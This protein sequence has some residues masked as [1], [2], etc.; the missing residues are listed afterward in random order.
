MTGNQLREA[1]RR[2]GWTQQQAARRLGVSQGYFSLLERNRRRLPDQLTTKLLRVL[3][4]SPTARP[5][6]RPEQWKPARQD[7]L[8]GALGALGYPAF[9]YLHSRR[10][11][12]PAELLL[13]S[14]T[15]PNLDSR[16]A[17]A[18]PWVV[19]SYADMDWDWLVRNAKLLD[20]QNRLGFTVT[21]ARELAEWRQR[22][23]E[24]PRLRAVEQ[25]LE[26]SRLAA[27][28]TFCHESL[29]QAERRWLRERRPLQA[30]RWNLL[31][32]LGPEALAHV[33]QD[34]AAAVAGFP[35]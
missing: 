23:D 30:Q 34:S 21:L 26:R 33:A 20:V 19:F 1:R 15:E 3:D 8:A 6:S 14:L 17:E 28:D 16:V 7:E 24:A 2:R 13:R 4:V 31:T 27:E 5:L 12:N 10:L 25:R 9:A 22:D 35:R 11:W 32:D 18:L 29:S